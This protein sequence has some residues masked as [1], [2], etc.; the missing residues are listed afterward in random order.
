M[1]SPRHTPVSLVRITDHLMISASLASVTITNLRSRLIQSA[2]YLTPANAMLSVELNYLADMLDD[3]KQ[4]YN[5]SQQAR[6]WSKR[7]HGAIWETTV[8]V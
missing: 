4:L 8:R 7:I 5:V 1:A 6:Q 3:I 2:A